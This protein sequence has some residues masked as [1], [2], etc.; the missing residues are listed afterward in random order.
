MKYVLSAS[1][2]IHVFVSVLM[3]DNSNCQKGFNLSLLKIA[4][5]VINQSFRQL[6]ILHKTI[7][8]E[9]KACVPNEIRGK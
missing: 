9:M 6:L 2:A 8:T 5:D 3:F 4:R 7:E 1:F